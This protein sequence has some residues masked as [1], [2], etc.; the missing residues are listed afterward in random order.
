MPQ[1]SRIPRFSS[2]WKKLSNRPGLSDLFDRDS[3]FV[4][5]SV[6]PKDEQ[7]RATTSTTHL[8]VS[9]QAKNVEEESDPVSE[10]EMV[11]PRVT[12]TT[13]LL[14]EYNKY[15]NTYNSHQVLDVSCWFL[16]FLCKFVCL[17]VCL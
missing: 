4:G 11:Q 3:G 15:S 12:G 8:S 2:H 14:Y 6:Q 1:P 17:F 5:S 7:Q 9:T 16:C 13:C 10:T